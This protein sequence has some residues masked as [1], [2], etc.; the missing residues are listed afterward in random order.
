MS[1]PLTIACTRAQ[2]GPAS[3][4]PGGHGRLRGRQSPRLADVVTNLATV[5][6]ETGQ[7]VALVSTAGLAS[8][9]EDI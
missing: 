9:A 8:S 5:C 2:F 3:G 1:E 6:A 4:P 7:R